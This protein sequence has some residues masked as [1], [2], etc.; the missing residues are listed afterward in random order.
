MTT[1]QAKYKVKQIID[2][3][4]VRAGDALSAGLVWIGAHTAMKLQSFVA[5]N[6]VLSALWLFAAYALARAY[7]R[8][9]AVPPDPQVSEQHH[10]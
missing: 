1:R 10:G 6:L 3:F 7:A 9:V 2:T 4:V 5:V 8:K